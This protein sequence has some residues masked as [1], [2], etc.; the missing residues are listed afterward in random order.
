[1]FLQSSDERFLPTVGWQLKFLA[2]G[3][4][5]PTG[6]TGQLFRCPGLEN[7]TKVPG[8]L[9]GVVLLFVPGNSAIIRNALSVFEAMVHSPYLSAVMSKDTQVEKVHRIKGGVC[10]RVPVGKSEELGPADP[11]YLPNPI[12]GAFFRGVAPLLRNASCILRVS[13]V[14]ICYVQDVVYPILAQIAI[15]AEMGRS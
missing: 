4:Q 8:V 14:Q 11:M 5:E 6:K 9:C 15:G 3:G 2:K 1:M 7:L 13:E 12:S 10:C